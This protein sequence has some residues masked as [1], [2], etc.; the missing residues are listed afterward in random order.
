MH[1]VCLGVMKKLLKCWT[2]GPYKLSKAQI[3]KMS[4]D[5]ELIKLFI[6]DE[7]SRKSRSL[8]DLP[9]F[10]ATEFRLFL[11][12][13]GIVVLKSNLSKEKY[14][15]FLLLHCAVF[16]LLTEA[17][18]NLEWNQLAQNLLNN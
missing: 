3:E 4:L 10:K 15:H 7:F 13:T 14:K 8:E 18:S 17:S 1:L 11:V 9:H 6:P 5:L 16:I 2:K 12:Y